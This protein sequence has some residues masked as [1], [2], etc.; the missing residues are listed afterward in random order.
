[1][2]VHIEFDPSV[3]KDYK[4]LLSLLQN[5]GEP[6]T[7]DDLAVSN[8]EEPVKETP[9][10]KQED[11]QPVVAE[12]APVEEVKAEEPA[13]VEEVKAEEPAPVETPEGP[14]N[15]TAPVKTMS[16]D[17]WTKILL[18]KR[19]ELGLLSPDGKSVGEGMASTR[20]MFNEFVKEQSK[21]YGSELPKKLSPEAL[22]AFVHEV[23]KHIAYDPINGFKVG[24]YQSD[25]PF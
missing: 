10:E 16:Q 20:A 9:C 7:E 17:E 8:T 14:V 2:K 22:Y 3:K 25:L 18:D 1:M 23:F 6:L 4:A 5:I 11:E 21:K 12:P 24:E 13:P 15:A 19:I